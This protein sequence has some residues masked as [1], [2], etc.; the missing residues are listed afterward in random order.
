MLKYTKEGTHENIINFMYN[1]G[2]IVMITS[3]DYQTNDICNNMQVR[4]F[5]EDYDISN[6][7]WNDSTF[8]FIVNFNSAPYYVLNISEY[9]ENEDT[10][11][12]RIQ[13]SCTDTDVSPTQYFR[14]NL[15]I[16]TNATSTM[17]IQFAE[18][19]LPIYATM[20]FVWA[21]VF[22]LVYSVIKD[23]FKRK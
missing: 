18:N 15:I 22:W 20:I 16:E 21:I 8:S 14:N 7:T 13:G 1:G 6:G 4:L 2:D 11:I 10:D 5:E 23:I 17:D 3:G 9:L 19:T 12:I